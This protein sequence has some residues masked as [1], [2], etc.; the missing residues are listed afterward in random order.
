[1]TKRMLIDGTHPEE[2]RVVITNGNR[3]DEYDVETSTKTQLKGNIYLAKVMRVEPSLQAAFVD[4]GGNRHGFLAFSEIHPD[5]YQIPVEDR[6]ALKRDVAQFEANASAAQAHV[7]QIDGDV[8]DV[9]AADDL[10]EDTT[11]VSESGETSSSDDDSD[12]EVSR[13]EETG[14]DL[15]AAEAATSEDDAENSADDN[16]GSEEVTTSSEENAENST[17]NDET[18]ADSD[19]DVI[20]A[21][22]PAEV[23]VK[24]NDGKAKKNRTPRQSDAPL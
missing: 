16:S 8:E 1:M 23:P 21:S 19:A 3:L 4:Y 18:A 12:A 7:D 14:E 2:V 6:E 11:E 24:E 20:E 10:D 9:D 13:E 17:K 5:Y 15:A 22:D